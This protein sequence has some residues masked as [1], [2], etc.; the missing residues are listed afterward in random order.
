MG[1]ACTSLRREVHIAGEGVNRRA[2]VLQEQFYRKPL[3]WVGSVN[4]GYCLSNICSILAFELLTI[5]P[6]RS[7]FLMD[8]MKNGKYVEEEGGLRVRVGF[9]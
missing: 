1:R 4:P 2:P 7:F 9:I 3:W 5:F 6:P 8:T